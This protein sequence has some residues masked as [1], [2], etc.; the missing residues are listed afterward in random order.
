MKNITLR[1]LKTS[2][3]L[4]ANHTALPTGFIDNGWLKFAPQA[5][6]HILWIISYCISTGKTKTET[7][8]YLA[9]NFDENEL[10]F[11]K[12]RHD[13]NNAD[14]RK[15]FWES[16]QS[17]T[18]VKLKLEKAGFNYP[19]NSKELVQLLVKWGIILETIEEFDLVIS[20]FP[21]PKIFNLK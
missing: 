7:L 19:S 21:S 11:F 1:S 16:R 6:T 15:E 17:E 13:F 5:A 20:P 8:K 18:K 4:E 3:Q 10:D 14:E 2:N 9:E 12:P